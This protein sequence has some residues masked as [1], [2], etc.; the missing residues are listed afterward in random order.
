MTDFAT[1]LY[2]V[3]NTPGGLVILFI[4]A[5][6]A[7][8]RGEWRWKREVLERD[9]TITHQRAL[10]NKL[11]GTTESNTNVTADTIRLL[12]RQLGDENSA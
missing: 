2:G 11:T 6:L 3:L 5:L 7:G 9:L 8:W 1:S 12:R 10:I 4:L